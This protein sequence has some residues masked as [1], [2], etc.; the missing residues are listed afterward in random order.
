MVGSTPIGRSERGLDECS[1]ACP[2]GIIVTIRFDHSSGIWPWDSPQLIN[3]AI[4]SHASFGKAR[5][6]LACQPL[7]PGDL[8]SLA[9]FNACM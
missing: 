6:S 3:A 4:C 8:R 2:F 1:P 7:S 5:K 9:F